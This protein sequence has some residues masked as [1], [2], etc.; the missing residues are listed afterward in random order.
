MNPLHEFIKEM[1]NTIQE[2]DNDNTLVTE[3]EKLVGKLVRDCS[4]LPDESRMP[5][6]Q[7]YARHPL[8]HDPD[9]QFEII[10][11]AWLPGQKTPIHDHDGTWGVEGVVCGRL[12]VTNFL[13]IGQPSADVVQLRQ[14][15]TMTVGEQST[16]Q[17]L[18]PADCHILEA[19]GNEP[20]VTIHVYGKQLR[21]FKVFEPVEGEKETYRAVDY[22][23]EYTAD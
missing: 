16:G 2:T 14:G 12:K 10:A 20:V 11:L 9:D 1:T 7:H 18:P 8:Y 15:G 4:W 6:E 21:K 3:A 17:L 13:R 5:S 19:A 23:V 22:C